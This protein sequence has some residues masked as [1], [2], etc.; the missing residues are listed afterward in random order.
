MRRGRPVTTMNAECINCLKVVAY[1][2]VGTGS[3]AL[4]AH[5]ALKRFGRPKH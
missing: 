4:L 5:W 1:V 3:I 2:I